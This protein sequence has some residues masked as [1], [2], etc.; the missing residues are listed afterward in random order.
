[1]RPKLVLLVLGHP[2]LDEDVVGVLSKTDQIS[3]SLFH[4]FLVGEGTYL[5]VLPVQLK[6]IDGLDV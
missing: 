2:P 3:I 1:V 6:V 4:K 5:V